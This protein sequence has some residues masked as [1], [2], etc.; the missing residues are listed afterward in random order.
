MRIAF[1]PALGETVHVSVGA[2]KP[3]TQL[4]FTASLS[5]PADYDQLASGLVKLQVWSDIPANGR[6]TGDWGEAEFKPVPATDEAGFSLLVDERNEIKTSLTLDFSVS[7]SGQRFSFTYRMVYPS[8]EIKWLGHYGHNGTLVLDRTDSDPVFLGDGWVPADNESYRR[9]SDGRAVQDF[10]VAKL[11]HPA[12]YT[13]YSVDESSFLHPKD[14]ALLILVPRLFPRPVV[15]LP[16]LI[17]GATPSGSISFTSRGT[18]TMSG[19]ASLLFTAC[20]SAGEVEAAVSRVINHCSSP[21]FRVVS[22]THGAVVLASASDK[23]PVEVAIIP[24]ASSNLLLQS[25]LPLRSLT[26]LVPGASQFC[27]FSVTRCDA[28]FFSREVVEASGESISFTLGQSGGKF[29]VAPIEWVRQGEEHWQVGIMSSVAGDGLPTPPPSPRLRPLPHR[30]SEN[31]SRAQSPDPSF[32][33]LPAPSSSDDQIAPGTSSH[34]IVHPSRR[35][36]VFAVIGHIILAFLNWFTRIFSRVKVQPK[37]VADERTP[38]LQEESSYPSAQPHVEVPTPVQKNVRPPQS[39]EQ[40]H[41]TSTSA[42]SANV[43]GGKTIILFQAPHSTSLFNVPIQLNGHEID[44]NVQKISNVLFIVDFSSTTGG[45]L[46][47]G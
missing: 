35:A 10:E 43:G 4:H 11:P 37:R 47:I 27:I 38:L 26:S 14:S 28:R 24:I 13:A 30:T 45:K 6:G 33:S 42:I 20:E 19:T 18:I 40:P 34:L 32:L 46:K 7:S 3:A 23:Y 41:I 21:R 12:N 39:E 25:S 22:Y 29:L 31:I 2:R 15:L 1:S 8:G 16:T 9:D 17:F 5:S 44:L 36:G